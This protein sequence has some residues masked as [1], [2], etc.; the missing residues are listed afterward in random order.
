MS[1]S[2][3]RRI[4]K[5]IG[6]AN[7]KSPS[8]DSGAESPS[9]DS[10]PELTKELQNEQGLIQDVVSSTAEPSTRKLGSSK[11]PSTTTSPPQS[12]LDRFQKREA[13]T[14]VKAAKTHATYKVGKGTP[15]SE[16]FDDDSPRMSSEWID[17]PG[18]PEAGSDED[19]KVYDGVKFDVMGKKGQA[20]EAPNV[21][22]D[23]GFV[24][25]RRTTR[26]Q[27]RRQHRADSADSTDGAEPAQKDNGLVPSALTIKKIN[28]MERSRTPSPN[29]GARI[30]AC[31][32]GHVA[33]TPANSPCISA[34]ASP[35]PTT[36]LVDRTKGKAE[37]RLSTSPDALSSEKTITYSLGRELPQ[38]P[39]NPTD[40]LVDRSLQV[41][42]SRCVRGGCSGCRLVG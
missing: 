3:R 10:K 21:E 5:H 8:P 28:D 33:P 22:K 25:E 14:S 17:M 11:Q 23:N 42:M 37:Y 20:A 27:S 31:S 35:A 4:G 2:L 24:Y 40:S 29:A 1:Y 16:H 36:L 26:S 39:S 7:S 34:T 32:P 13:K 12:L 9:D 15:F 30:N 38:P 6:N 18:T 19:V 41:V